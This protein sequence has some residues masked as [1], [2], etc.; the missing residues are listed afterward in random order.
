MVMIR[1]FRTGTRNR[2]QYRIVAIEKRKQRQGR[3]LENLGTYDPR[4]G[5][6]TAV[7]LAAVERWIERGAQPS[8]TV[9]S[10]IRR[11]RAAV[12]AAAAS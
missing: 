12:P 8:D 3:F 7:D 5:G 11:A 2:P 4:R 10:L 1:L 9:A 6:G